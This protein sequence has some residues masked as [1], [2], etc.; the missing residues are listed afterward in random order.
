MGWT[1][2]V[3]ESTT[4]P[5]RT[6]F[7]EQTT[8]DATDPGPDTMTPLEQAIVTVLMDFPEAYRAVLTEFRRLRGEPDDS[9]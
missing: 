2:F 6:V 3:T 8:E 9:P 7:R 5:P 1:T 4:P